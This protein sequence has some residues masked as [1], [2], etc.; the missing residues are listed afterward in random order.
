MEIA[1]M[2]MDRG[3]DVNTADKVSEG[4]AL[5]FIIDTI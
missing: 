5:I 4:G 3:A 2:L 1:K